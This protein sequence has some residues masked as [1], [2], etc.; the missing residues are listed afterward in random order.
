MTLT[1]AYYIA[2]HSWAFADSKLHKA[3]AVLKANGCASA[4]FKVLK[5]LQAREDSRDVD[6]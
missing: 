4:E 2:Q 1:E 5:T 6:R 3:R